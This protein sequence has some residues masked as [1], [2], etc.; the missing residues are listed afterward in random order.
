[1]AAEHHDNSAFFT[2]RANHGGND[3]LEIGRYENVGK[4]AEESSEGHVVARRRGEFLRAN[5]VG[6]TLDRNCSD[7]RQVRL[8]E[9]IALRL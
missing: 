5:L 8:G 9:I 3:R 6:A 1:V 2:V 4:S 7:L